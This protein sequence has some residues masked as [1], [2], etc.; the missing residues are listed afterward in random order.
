ME[1]PSQLAF[2]GGLFS[3]RL[4]LLRLLHRI[5]LSSTSWRELLSLK[6]GDATDDVDSARRLTKLEESLELLAAQSPKDFKS[7]SRSVRHILVTPLAVG[8][9][10]DWVEATASIR[11]SSQYLSSPTVTA[12]DCAGLLVN[13]ATQA[14]LSRAGVRY[15]E[16]HR[17]RCRALCLESELRF[18]RRLPDAAAAQM[19]LTTI[20]DPGVLSGLETN[21][22]TLISAVIEAV[23][24]LDFPKWVE[25]RVTRRHPPLRVRRMVPPQELLVL[26]HRG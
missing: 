20:L 12:A 9:V 18:L 4:I 25:P 26:D 21:H 24:R 23:V 3:S 6:V 16:P 11:V 7:V 1:Q 22:D 8:C 19:T 5:V 13:A 17:R 2:R 15:S 10:V 14:R